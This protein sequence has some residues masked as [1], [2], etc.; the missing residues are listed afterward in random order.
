M[1]AETLPT[2]ILSRIDQQFF[3]FVRENLGKSFSDLL[4]ILQINSAT[5]FLMTD[6]FLDI[7]DMDIEHE[8]LINLK[9]SICFRL[10][11]GSTVIKPGIVAGFKCFREALVNK[12]ETIM[13]Q[14]KKKKEVVVFIH[15]S[16]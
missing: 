11:D 3:S 5:C 6:D 9:K 15:R 7:L 1:V 16:R 10:K 2:D 14:M 12:K 4:E 8:Q 13:K